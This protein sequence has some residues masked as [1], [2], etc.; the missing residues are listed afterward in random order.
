[1]KNKLTTTI[2]SLTIMGMLVASPLAAFA[3]EGDVKTPKLN[4]SANF[5]TVINSE[6]FKALTKFEDNLV[7]RDGNRDEDAPR[8]CHTSV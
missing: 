6:D 5:C 8:P 1:M 4:P 2:S 7:K 3:K